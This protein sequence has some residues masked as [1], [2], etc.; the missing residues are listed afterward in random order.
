MILTEK[1][2]RK[3]EISSYIRIAVDQ[4]RIILDR[5]GSE[6][7]PYEWTEQDIYVQ[8]QNFLGCGEFVKSIRP[9]QASSGLPA[10][11]EF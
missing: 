7:E 11:V 9:A 3:W 2:L 4:R 1:N 6:P 5:F 10:G 8:I